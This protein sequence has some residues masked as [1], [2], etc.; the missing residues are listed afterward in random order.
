VALGIT[1]LGTVF[2]G[3]LPEYFIRAVTWSLP[4]A[5]SSVAR[6]VR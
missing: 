2:I 1:A 4:I 6:L 5:Q 3:I